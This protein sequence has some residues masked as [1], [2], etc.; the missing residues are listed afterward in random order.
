MKNKENG[1]KFQNCF[2]WVVKFI[3]LLGAPMFM[4]ITLYK[5]RFKLDSKE[6]KKEYGYLTEG[7]KIRKKYIY[8]VYPFLLLHRFIF[9]FI[10]LWFW[11]KPSLQITFLMIETLLY[12]TFLVAIRIN[13]NYGIDLF[14]DLFNEFMLLLLYSFLYYFVDGGLIYGTPN[15]VNL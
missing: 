11:N 13:T 15:Q 6:F 14:L 4:L 7:M 2:Q 12:N 3:F 5:N 8:L 9:T 10:P 1:F